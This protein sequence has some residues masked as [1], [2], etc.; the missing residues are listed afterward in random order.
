MGSVHDGTEDGCTPSLLAIKGL[1]TSPTFKKHWFW[2]IFPTSLLLPLSNS[3]DCIRKKKNVFASRFYRAY[4]SIKV[5]S[6]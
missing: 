2:G 3:C 6:N 5:I 1:A 4:Y